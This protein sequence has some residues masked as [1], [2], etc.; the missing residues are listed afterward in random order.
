MRLD[1]ENVG[2][3]RSGDGQW[4]CGF[5]HALVGGDGDAQ[6]FHSAS[7]FGELIDRCAGLLDVFEVVLG[8]GV[9]RVL[10]FVDVPAAVRV[11]ADSAFGTD[12]F[13]SSS[14][15]GHVV[16]ERLTALG[17]LNLHRAAV[18]EARQDL[19]HLPGGNGGQGG[20]DGDCAAPQ[21]GLR[22][23]RKAQRTGKPGCGFCVAVFGEW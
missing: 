11:N 5:A 6:V 13:S 22:I 7:D 10:R 12:A 8:E 1:D 18:P 23:V 20:V 2:S 3:S 19:G 4:V 15:S 16:G 14:H 17:D 9:D 21:F